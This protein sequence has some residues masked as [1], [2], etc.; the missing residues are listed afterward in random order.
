MVCRGLPHVWHREL[1]RYR[2]SLPS[3]YQ[4]TYRG[5]HAQPSQR[6]N[7]CRDLHVMLQYAEVGKD[8][9]PIV[10]HIVGVADRDQRQLLRTRISHVSCNIEKVFKEEKR[11]KS[12]GGRLAAICKVN[13]QRKRDKQ[14]ENGAAPDHQGLAEVAEQ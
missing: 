8:I 5:Q 4:P 7:K 10:F 1:R 9:K 3:P 2:G 11:T 13:R 14:L 12:C 6:A